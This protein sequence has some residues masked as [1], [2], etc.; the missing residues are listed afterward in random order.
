MI[1]TVNVILLDPESTV[2][3]MAS[4]EDNPENNEKAEKLFL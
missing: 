4:F 3:Q 1:S 2:L